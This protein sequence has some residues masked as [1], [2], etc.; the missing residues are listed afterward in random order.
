MEKGSVLNAAK[1]RRHPHAPACSG[2]RRPDAALGLPIACEHTESRALP[3]QRT[4]ERFARD[5][6]LNHAYLSGIQH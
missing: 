1:I 5:F 6:I 3:G 2:V 4:P